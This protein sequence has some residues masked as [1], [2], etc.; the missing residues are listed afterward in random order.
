MT[1]HRYLLNAEGL[2]CG[3]GQCLAI[4]DVFYHHGT[5]LFQNLP[6]TSP[7]DDDEVLAHNNL[8]SGDDDDEVLSLLCCY[9]DVCKPLDTEPD[10]SLFLHKLVPLCCH[11]A[12][13][14]NEPSAG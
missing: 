6:T 1:T 3:V 2:W 10:S 13:P 14:G 5:Q 4:L 7:H 8:N 12:V 9:T 11:T